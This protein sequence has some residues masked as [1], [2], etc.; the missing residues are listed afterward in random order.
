[1]VRPNMF[2][3]LL[4]DV[5]VCKRLR[6]NV[7]STRCRFTANH[8]K[9]TWCSELLSAWCHFHLNWFFPLSHLL[10]S[11]QTCVLS[12]SG[13]VHFSW[14]LNYLQSKQP[15]THTHTQT[16]THIHTH[17]EPIISCTIPP[18]SIKELQNSVRCFFYNQQEVKLNQLLSWD[19]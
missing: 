2:I 9:H 15:Y 14:T 11:T 17:D 19:P 8:Q 6:D 1:M 18:A 12:L 4:P 10:R 16:H 7:L 5:D 3:E 13:K